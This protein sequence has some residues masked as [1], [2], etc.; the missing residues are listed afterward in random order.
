[1]SLYSRDLLGELLRYTAWADTTV[2]RAVLAHEPARADATLVGHLRHLHMVQRAFLRVWRGESPDQAWSQA[3]GIAD[4]GEL[5]Q[6]AQPF[7]GEADAFIASLD[8][9]ALQRPMVMPWTNLYQ[10]KLRRTFAVTSLGDTIFQV[11]SHSTYH[12]GQVNI[13]LRAVGGEP[14]TVDHILWIWFGKP[15]AEAA[16]A[17]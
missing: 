5:W 10:G 8:D 17:V 16:V 11:V 14:P 13:R 2:W 6:W 12:R 3:S 7:Y 15:A 9:D 1:M 4:A